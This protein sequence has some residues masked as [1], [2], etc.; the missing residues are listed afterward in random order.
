M[1]Y[2]SLGSPRVILTTLF[3][4]KVQTKMVLVLVYIDDLLVLGNCSQLILQTRSDLQLKVKMKDL[5][6]LKFFW[7][8]EFARSKEGIVMNQMKYALE[9]ITEMGL[10]GAKPAGSPLEPNQKLTSADYDAF[11]NN[12]SITETQHTDVENDN[13]LTDASQYQS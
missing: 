8:I 9:L 1:L 3:S 11:I 4:K 10:G 12:Q 6:E 2:Y 5:G 13:L 7:G